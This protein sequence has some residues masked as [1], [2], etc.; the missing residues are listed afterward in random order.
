M[1]ETELLQIGRNKRELKR[2]Q[3]KYEN[4]L[5]ESA[6]RGQNSDGMPYV[7]RVFDTS[8]C[9]AEEKWDLEREYKILYGK[10]QRLIEIAR[11]YIKQFPDLTLRMVLTL[12]YINCMLTYDVAAAIGISDKMC[13]QI[14]RV[15][16][17][18]VF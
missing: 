16:F 2:L 15:H 9:S 8:M 1:T 17:L 14:L 6:V 7:G 5:G 13:R 12:K 4:L 10:N 18:N 3:T 11:D